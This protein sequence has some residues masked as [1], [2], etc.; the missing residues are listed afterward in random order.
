MKARCNFLFLLLSVFIVK[1]ASLPALLDLDAMAQDF[2]LE[3]KQI[4]IAEF[5]QALNPSIIQWNNQL[6]F[7]FRIRDP[8]TS[9]ADGIGLVWLDDNFEPISTPQVLHL[10]HPFLPAFPQDPKLVAVGNKLYI[11]YSNILD[12][13]EKGEFRRMFISEL[14]QGKKHFFAEPPKVLEKFEGENPNRREKNWVPFEYQGNL[15]LA[16]TIKPHDIFDPLYMKN[17]CE[18]FATSE[19]DITWNWGELRGGTPALQLGDHYL[20]FFHSSKAMKTK[21]SNGKMMG[22]YFMGAYTFSSLPPFEIT[23]ISPEP[24]VGDKF[25]NGPEYKMWKPLRVV[26][27]G[28]FINHE[29]YLWVVYGREDHEMWVVKLDKQKLMDSLIP[30]STMR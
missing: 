13:T 17:E 23:A 1:H 11:V 16:R 15:L 29:D 19:G 8:L 6:L 20:A 10:K 14:H 18:H 24:I 25:Y 2:V 12:K 27:P 4:E 21:Q 22:H 5:P 26:F 28:G 30:V 3:M 9:A 7:C